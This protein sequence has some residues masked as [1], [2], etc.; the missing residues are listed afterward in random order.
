[1]FHIGKQKQRIA[2]H[3]QDLMQILHDELID[4]NSQ[5]MSTISYHVNGQTNA[6]NSFTVTA[7]QFS[8]TTALNPSA[9][10]HP[11]PSELLLAAYAASF[12]QLLYLV[13]EEQLIELKQ[14]NVKATGQLNPA[15]FLGLAKT[16]R[17]GLQKIQLTIK[18]SSPASPEEL[19]NLLQVARDRSP[20]ADNLLNPTPAGFTLDLQ[21]D[22]CQLKSVF[23]QLN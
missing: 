22:I 19:V 16:D 9:K 8:L 6:D 10:T 17:A 13:A 18:L 15:W 5:H 2:F 7:G 14:V 23:T 20:V 12:A 3:H 11:D 21:E 4:A 1:M